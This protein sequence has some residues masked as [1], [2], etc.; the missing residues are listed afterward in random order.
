V[1]YHRGRAEFVR[2]VQADLEQ[3]FVAELTETVRGARR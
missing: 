1:E 2:E 3:F